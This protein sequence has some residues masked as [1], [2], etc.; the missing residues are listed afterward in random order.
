MAHEPV[1]KK[2][3]VMDISGWWMR[4]VRLDSGYMG[5]RKQDVSS[6][7]LSLKEV[8]G[9]HSTPAPFYKESLSLSLSLSGHG[10]TA[11]LPC[12][13][14]PG[15][16]C[17]LSPL[18]WIWTLLLVWKYNLTMCLV[19]YT[20]SLQVQTLLLGPLPVHSGRSPASVSRHIYPSESRPRKKLQFLLSLD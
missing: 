14:G 12:G 4:E 20:L 3:N 17:A 1:N 19:G 7:L 5:A 8:P 6:F 9:S 15:L 10:T 18:L 2:C 11:T 13:L 16:L